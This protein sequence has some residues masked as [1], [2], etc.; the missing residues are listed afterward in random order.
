ML[1]NNTR[2]FA[3]RRRHRSSLRSSWAAQRRSNDNRRLHSSISFSR[4]ARSP[5]Y[6]IDC[7]HSLQVGE[8]VVEPARAKATL[9]AATMLAVTLL[10]SFPDLN[11]S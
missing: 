9:V 4:L 1:R 11:A 3:P 7:V 8:S 6:K 10:L 5:T 2:R